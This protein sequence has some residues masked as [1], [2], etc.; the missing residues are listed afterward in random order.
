MNFARV[1]PIP[2]GTT[3]GK[4]TVKEVDSKNPNRHT[5]YRCVCACGK[6]G[7]VDHYHLLGGFSKGCRAC[8]GRAWPGVCKQGHLLGD[9]GKDT[10]GACKLCRIAQ[11]LR[12][13]YGM[14]IEDYVALWTY[15]GGKCAICGR[16]LKLS[17][18]FSILYE[19]AA[20][21]A[22]V[23]HRHVPKKDKVQPAKRT[24]VRGLLCGG[25]YAGCNAKLGHVDDIT[26]LRSAVAYL[27]A[28][29]AQRLFSFVDE[30]TERS[31]KH[32]LEASEDLPT[33]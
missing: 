13:S 5:K 19:E 7:V 1:P 11:H 30:A 28:L 25:R 27:E 18:A 6:E 14:T 20:T 22:E 33:Q 10:R 16:A 21:R 31:I 32:D 26:W 17:E 9:C 12:R 15:Q 24:L 3:F 29:P 23:D 2:A 8:S 4:W